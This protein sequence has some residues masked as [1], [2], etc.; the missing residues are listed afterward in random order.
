MANA[1]KQWILD[2]RFTRVWLAQLEASKDPLSSELRKAAAGIR[3]AR[4]ACSADVD[5]AAVYVFQQ[6]LNANQRT[7]SWSLEQLVA[8]SRE[9]HEPTFIAPSPISIDQAGRWGPDYLIDIKR[10]TYW[11]FKFNEPNVSKLPSLLGRI[12]YKDFINGVLFANVGRF[13][14]D[15]ELMRL[16]MSHIKLAC[17]SV[18]DAESLVLIEPKLKH[19][20]TN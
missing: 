6:G 9:I 5:E 7:S 8:A 20:Q 16:V 3:R 17:M 4:V 1:I 18:Y 12:F 15:D 13:A 19:A 2:E 11:C 10:R 14:S